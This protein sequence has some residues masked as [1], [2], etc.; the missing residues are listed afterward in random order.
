MDLWQFTPLHE[1]A[2]K[3]RAE[4]CSLL[5]AHGADPGLL[6][7]HSK[8]PIMVAPSRDL[9]DRMLYEYK[10]HALLDAARQADLA[11]I[12][13]YSTPDVANFKHPFTGDTSLVSCIVFLPPC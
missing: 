10:G 8:S 6:N 12:K 4:V 13:K 11:R 7:C 5:L 9:Q 2:S 3:S 1:A